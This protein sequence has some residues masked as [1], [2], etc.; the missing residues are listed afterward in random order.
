LV[1]SSGCSS[2]ETSCAR[3]PH[4][5]AMLRLAGWRAAGVSGSKGS[6]RWLAAVASHGR[7]WPL[8]ELARG[9]GR[10]LPTIVFAAAAAVVVATPKLGSQGHAV[11]AETRD[12][13]SALTPLQVMDVT[14]MVIERVSLPMVPMSMQE[15]I[16][17]KCVQRVSHELPKHLTDRQLQQLRAGVD[18]AGSDI[19]TEEREKM[20]KAVAQTLEVA[21]LPSNMR[22][23]V[24]C[25][26]IDAVLGDVTVDAMVGATGALV[27]AAGT[28]TVNSAGSLLDAEGRKRIATR[29]NE[30]VDLPLLS[31]EQEQVLFEKFVNAVVEP[32]EK[33]IPEDMRSH[34]KAASAAELE[35]LKQ[36]LTEM[37]LEQLPGLPF[38][39]KDK[40]R[41]MLRVVVDFFVESFIDHSGL[42][43]VLLAPEVQLERIKQAE[44]DAIM[45]LELA[46]RQNARREAAMKRHLASVRSQKAHLEREVG[47]SFAYKAAMATGIFLLVDVLVVAAVYPFFR[48]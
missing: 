20:V 41:Q 9:S 37:L 23:K 18:K 34:L 19:S 31:E 27:A 38:L 44:Q 8:A 42:D 36:H 28:A 32:L 22:E 25:A 35:A 15:A 12:G 40:E 21:L 3:A 6:R 10:Q 47:H 11:L 2:I 39:D 45:A 48:K 30:Q 4:P 43:G 14:N 17:A 13:P 24:A 26:I 29:L 46:R 5:A 16:L 33:L 7:R 1:L